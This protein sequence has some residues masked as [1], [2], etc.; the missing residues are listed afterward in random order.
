MSLGLVAALPAS[1]QMKFESLSDPEGEEMAIKLMPM[2]EILSNRRLYALPGTG[3]RDRD[4]EQINDLTRDD[5]CGCVYAN[6]G[7]VVRAQHCEPVMKADNDAMARLGVVRV[8]DYDTMRRAL[9][10]DRQAFREMSVT[11]ALGQI[12]R[13][14]RFRLERDIDLALKDPHLLL[15][16]PLPVAYR[17]MGLEVIRPEPEKRL[18]DQC[19]IVVGDNGFA[20]PSALSGFV[21]RAMLYGAKKYKI[22][23]NYPLGALE[24]ISA[25]DPPGSWELARNGLIG[26]NLPQY[27]YNQYIAVP[28]KADTR[29][30]NR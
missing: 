20:P 13:S 24:R 10:P 19:D 30:N 26:R 16:A 5:V 28:E 4:G 18:W 12:N 17:L 15:L 27:G 9:L 8:I 29:K 6:G 21:A 11:S 25:A 3:T 22:T 2:Y 14:E 23:V 7:A 1:A